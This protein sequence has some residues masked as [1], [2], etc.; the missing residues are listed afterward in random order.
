MTPET[1]KLKNHL[2]QYISG[3]IG[4]AFSGGVDSS[5]L[6]A[7]LS[8]IRKESPFLLEALTFHTVLHQEEEKRSAEKITRAMNVPHHFFFLNPLSLPDIRHNPTD[9][10][11]LCKKMLF[12]KILSYAQKHKLATLL[13]GTNADD[14]NVY[15]PGRRALKELGVLS[16]LAELGFSKETIRKM[17]AELRLECASKPAAPCLATRF[18]Y[19]TDLSEE[20]IRNV[21]E[22]E[23]FLKSLF[24][25]PEN[26]RI[27]IH[28]T[29]CRI[30]VPVK[31]FPEILQFRQ[32]IIEGLK[33]IGF[34]YITLD[35]EGFRSGSMDLHLPL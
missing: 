7:V 8:L 29:I 13:D 31:L 19:G 34:S 22:A 3:G 4:L 2:K 6:L 20:L 21:A 32:V 5:L 10:C 12:S 27:R 11:Y 23:N 9:R 33:R 1:E 14:L 15:R 25:G 17:A 30:E 28:K 26:I 16:P 35:L 24:P 18:E